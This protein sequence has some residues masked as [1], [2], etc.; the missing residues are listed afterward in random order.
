M[1]HQD[2]PDKWFERRLKRMAM[3]YPFLENLFHQV[4][5][6]VWIPKVTL[7]WLWNFSVINNFNFLCI[8]WVFYPVFSFSTFNWKFKTI[9]IRNYNQH[10]TFKKAWEEFCRNFISYIWKSFEVAVISNIVM[11]LIAVLPWS[12]FLIKMIAS[13]F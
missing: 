8:S 13:I 3:L 12:G 10:L 2:L 7:K 6:I 4:A 1:H 11:K 9:S 5:F